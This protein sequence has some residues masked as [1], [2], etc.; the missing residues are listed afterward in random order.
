MVKLLLI[1]SLAELTIL[2]WQ[3][4]EIF[5]SQ[6]VNLKHFKLKKKKLENLIEFD[7]FS[8]AG[9]FLLEIRSLNNK[10]VN[11]MSQPIQICNKNFQANFKILY[12]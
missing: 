8:K 5:L 11:I 3:S 6:I 9:K 7:R 1:W 4:S 10:E 2:P 12:L